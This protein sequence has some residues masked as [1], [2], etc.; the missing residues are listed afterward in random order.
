MLKRTA[1][2]T[3]DW[4][5]V[6]TL[7]FLQKTVA[8]FTAENTYRRDRKG[9]HMNKV[10]HHAGRYMACH[11]VSCGDDEEC[12]R[13]NAIL[14][15]ATRNQKHRK[16]CEC[17]VILYTFDG[18]AFEYPGSCNDILMQTCFLTSL[19]VTPVLIATRKPS[20]GPPHLPASLPDGFKNPGKFRQPM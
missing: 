2:G 8:A 6:A 10:A 11:G 20:W 1:S 4:C 13:V 7:V 14:R 18:E 5:T 15:V 17:N 3:P 19:D 12:Q 9:L 16:V